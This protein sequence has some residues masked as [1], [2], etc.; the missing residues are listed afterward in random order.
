MTTATVERIVYEVD[1]AGAT[2]GAVLCI[3]GLGGTSN[4][5]TALLPALAREQV[6]RL[7]LPGSGRSARVEGELSIDRFVKAC[8]RV[9]AACRVERV[10]VLAH[11]MGT[12]VATHL[13]AAEPARV[14]SL[15]LFGPLLAPADAARPPLQARAT[16]VR[17]EG[18]AGLQAVTDALLPLALASQTHAGRHAA[19]AYVRETL[20]R[21]DPDGYAR[22]TD[23]L[24]AAVPADP[25]RIGCPTLLVTGDQDNVAPPSAVRQMA[26]RIRGA[27]VEVLAGCGHWTPIERPDAC[28]DALRRFHERRA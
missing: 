17:A 15:A 9:L 3:H 28:I 23:A 25:E 14:A 13:A 7:D 21:Q 6:I 8:L 1:H 19:V 27:R 20:M 12:I 18:V 11:S 5:W 10:R 22:S 2:G 24:A 16:K 4:T 26:D